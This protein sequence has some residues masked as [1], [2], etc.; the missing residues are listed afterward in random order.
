MPF[1]VGANSQLP[2]LTGRSTAGPRW[3]VGVLMN[4]AE[5]DAEGQARIGAL[6]EGLANFGWTE[7]RELQIEC[8]WFAGDPDRARYARL[9]RIGW[10]GN[11]R[12]VNSWL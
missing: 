2:L 7:W 6:R 8:L 4:L 3:R 9:P 11:A 10:E 1:I 5:S 12:K